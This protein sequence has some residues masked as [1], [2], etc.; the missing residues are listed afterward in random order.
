MIYILFYVDLKKFVWRNKELSILFLVMEFVVNKEMVV[1][2]LR[3]EL[4]VKV[5]VFFY[6]LFL[7]SWGLK[8]DVFVN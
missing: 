2:G 5:F 3:V 7:D 1:I 4:L 6:G 8:S